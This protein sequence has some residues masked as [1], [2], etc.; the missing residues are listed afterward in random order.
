MSQT[1]PETPQFS[2]ISDEEALYDTETTPTT[3]PAEPTRPSKP[4]NPLL[5]PITFPDLPAKTKD[6]NLY[7]IMQMQ[8]QMQE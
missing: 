5:A 6:T 2:D 1:R 4:S 7:H 8:K 3:G